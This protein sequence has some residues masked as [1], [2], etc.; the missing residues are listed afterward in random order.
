MPQ[1]FS[2]EVLN[3]LLGL[4]VEKITAEK[5]AIIGA[6]LEGGILIW[7]KTFRRKFEFDGRIQLGSEDNPNAHICFASL[8]PT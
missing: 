8:L 3:S 2:S 6:G 5:I 7:W 4:L 1:S